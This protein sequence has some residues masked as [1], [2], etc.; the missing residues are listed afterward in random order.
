MSNE[1]SN[2]KSKNTGEIV[3]LPSHYADLFPDV[4]ELTDEDVECTD[5]STPNEPETLEPTQPLA[6]P[7][8]ELQP[9]D[10][11]EPAKRP[12]RK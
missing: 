4:L 9:I 11:T 6:E 8:V 5:C 10:I 7:D 12:R 1:F 2:F 3:S